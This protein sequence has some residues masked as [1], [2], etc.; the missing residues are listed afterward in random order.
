[1]TSSNTKLKLVQNILNGDNSVEKNI[2]ELHNVSVE[3]LES[4]KS[5]YFFNLGRNVK[6]SYNNW[7]KLS[8]KRKVA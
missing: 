8:R 6:V 1:M 4:W 5:F 2:M 7:I 3:E